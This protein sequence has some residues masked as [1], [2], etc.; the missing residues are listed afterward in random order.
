MQSHIVYKEGDEIAACGRIDRRIMIRHKSASRVLQT[1]LDLLEEQGGGQAILECGTY[2]IDEPVRLPSRVTV[3]GSGQAT[4]LALGEGNAEGIVLLADGKELVKLSDFTCQGAPSHESSAGVVLDEC[5]LC[6]IEKVYARDFSGYGLWLR[7]NTFMSRLVNCTTSGNRRAGTYLEGLSG[8]HMDPEGPRAGRAGDYLPNLVMGCTSLGE[9]GHAFEL[10]GAICVN[11][12]G[13]L[14]FQPQGHGFYFHEAS[15]SAL[16]TGSRCFQGLK[17]GILADNTHEL[18]VSGNIMCW[19]RGHGIELSHV[20]W[21]AVCGN[22][23]IDIGGAIE[24]R[25]HG[26]YLHGDTKSVQVTSNTIFCWE[27]QQPMLCGIYEAEECQN[28][29]ITHNSINYYTDEAVFSAGKNTNATHNLG[30]PGM[31]PEPGREPFRTEFRYPDSFY[32]PF[33]RERL[34]RF[35]ASTRRRSQDTGGGNQTE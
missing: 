18:N 28:N 8:S 4:V 1:V 22:E 16:L 20:T 21:S 15:N 14:A 10:S 7:R 2:E 26:V 19:N 33:T 17:N 13:C 31:Y 23:F 34:G 32:V 30:V 27:G 35:L 5:G 12:V 29:Q 3:R 9:L 24:P 11:L 6:E 25:A